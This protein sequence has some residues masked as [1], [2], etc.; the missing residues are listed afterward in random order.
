MFDKAALQLIE[1]NNV[2]G[3]YGV[4]RT[5]LCNLLLSYKGWRT[6][7]LVSE[8]ITRIRRVIRDVKQ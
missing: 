7:M 1:F 6:Q 3:L 8:S 2:I 5:V 4:K